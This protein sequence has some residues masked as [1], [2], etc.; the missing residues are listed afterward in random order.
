MAD[1]DNVNGHRYLLVAEM[2]DPDNLVRCELAFSPITVTDNL[3]SSLGNTG[4]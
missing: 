2:D 3:T 4:S 1:L